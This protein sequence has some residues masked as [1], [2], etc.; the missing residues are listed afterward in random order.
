M[1]LVSWIHVLNIS[2][3]LNLVDIKIVL[4]KPPHIILIVADDL[5]R[6][7]RFSSQKYFYISQGWN[8]VSFHGSNQI[9]TPNIDSLAYS[10]VILQNYYVDPICTPSRSA[11]MT[12]RHPIHT[13]RRSSVQSRS[14]C[15]SSGL[16]DNVLVGAAPYSLSPALTI[17]PQ[18]LNSRGY[19]SHAVGKAG[20][21]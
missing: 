19:Q 7:Q 5:V 3:L 20:Q 16:Q 11:L 12:G 15:L 17:L 1:T 13:G 9:P 10:G 2:L 4:G 8:D 18:H 6:P 21:Q 14:R